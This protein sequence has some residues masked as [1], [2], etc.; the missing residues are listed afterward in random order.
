MLTLFLMTALFHA[1]PVKA[2]PEPI[3]VGI[4]GPVLLPHW[5]P[6]GMWPA[7]QMAAQEIND[8]GGVNVSNVYRNITLVEGNEYA[9]DPETGEYNEA[10]AVDE[11]TRL[12]IDEECEFVIGGFRTEVTDDII[13]VAMDYHVPFFINGA[14]TDELISDTVGGNYDRYKYL[15]RVNPINSTMLFRTIAGCLQGLIAKML[16]L[17][18]RVWYEGQPHPQVRVAVLTED[19]AWTQTMH[20]Y[21]TTP[22][23]YPMVLGSFANVTYQG[24]IPEDQVDC[25]SW[26]SDIKDSKAR[27][28]IHILSGRVGAYLIGQW[29]AMDV[30]AIPVGINVVAQLQD[31]WINTGGACEYESI[32]NFVGTGTPITPELV[33][34]WDKFTNYTKANY[35]SDCP[36]GCWPIYT[37]F[38]AYDT[39]YTLKEAIERAGTTDPDA[40]PDVGGVGKLIREIEATE[41]TQ[42]NGIFRYTGPNGTGH[43]VF[44]NAVGPYWPAPQY[45]RALMAQWLDGEMEVVCP[46]D[47]PYTKHWYIPPWLLPL[48]ADFDEDLDVDEDD[49]WHFC[50]AFIEYWKTGEYDIHCDFDDEGIIDEDDLWEFCGLFIDYYKI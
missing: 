23:V 1:F 11:I 41:R 24:R 26:L 49:L 28:M 18:G 40:D 31:H 42:L 12:I 50:E 43:D 13:E 34:F 38:G 30:P 5:E 10:K 6:A 16:P 25:S 2:T 21:L 46:M 29:A 4:I 44:C 14:S 37:A 7:A 33:E 45:V 35:P 47:Q 3:K 27:I 15:F 22:G 48:A 20:Y 19:L 9:I 39:L 17:Y 32:L 36:E 8:A